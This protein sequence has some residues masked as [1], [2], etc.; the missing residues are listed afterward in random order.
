M[1]DWCS[2]LKFINSKFK[3]CPDFVFIIKYR[4]GCQIQKSLPH[5]LR[6]LFTILTILEQQ[7]IFI[8]I[9]EVG[10]HCSTMTEQCQ[11]IT[12]YLLSS[13][14]AILK[15][16]ITFYKL[17]RVTNEI[18]YLLFYQYF[19]NFRMMQ[20]NDCNSRSHKNSYSCIM[21]FVLSNV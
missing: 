8:S 6:P 21:G 13:G 11:K 2:I 12:M 9:L 18:K 17:K 15:C 3:L 19:L 20:K 14:N 5:W 10:W 4:T 16:V 7:I 1:K